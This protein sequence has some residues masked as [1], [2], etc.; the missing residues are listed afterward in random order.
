MKT[1]T[2]RSLAARNALTGGSRGVEHR[3]VIALFAALLVAAPSPHR[4]RAERAET[5]G[6][7]AEAAREYEAAFEEDRTW[8]CR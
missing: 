1:S 4:A 3:G 6:R 7:V 8:K 5:L 2:A